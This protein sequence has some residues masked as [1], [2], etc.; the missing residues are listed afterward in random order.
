LA[1]LHDL[2]RAGSQ[3]AR[4]VYDDIVALAKLGAVNFAV[5]F[6]P[7]LLPSGLLALWLVA[8]R[9]L[10]R[11][12]NE[13]EHARRDSVAEAAFAAVFLCLGAHLV[14]AIAG[15]AHASDDTGL[16]LAGMMFGAIGFVTTVATVVIAGIYSFA[17]AVLGV[18]SRRWWP[19]TRLS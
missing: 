5:A 3:P 4:C 9:C 11:P 6:V 13:P 16:G 1:R 17:A 8:R 18:S 12:A 2:R 7:S 15:V 10:R 14:I 19:R